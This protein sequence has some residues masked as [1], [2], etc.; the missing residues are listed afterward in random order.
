MKRFLA[1]LLIIAMLPIPATFAQKAEPTVI[2]EE[3][4]D[5]VYAD[6]W[7]DIEDIETAKI[8]AKRGRNASADDYAAIVD[9]VIAAVE[10]SDTFVE[11]SIHRNG[12]FFTWKTT[13]GVA[14][15]YSP[16]LRA[17]IRNTAIKDADPEDYADIETTSYAV[18]GGSPS[19]K[20]VA[21][22][23]PYYGLDSSFTTTYPNEAKAIAQATGG[24]ATTYKTSAATIDAIADALESCAVVIF[25]SHGDTD[26]YSMTDKYDFVSR[27]NTSYICLQSGAGLTTADMADVTGTYGTYNH[28]YYGGTDYENPSMKYYCV[29]GTVIANH[30]EK[31]APNSMLWM[32]ICLGMATDGLEKPL[33]NKGVEVVYGY[34]Q[35]V[36]FDYDYDWESVFWK[37]MKND[38]TVAQSISAMKT[39]VGEW[40]DCTNKDCNTIAKARQNYCAFPI[41]VSSE[42]AYPGKGNVDNLQTVK[43][44]WKLKGS[45]TPTELT[46]ATE[47]TEPTEPITGGTFKKVTA[48][49]SDWSGKYLIVNETSAD[50]CIVF[51]GTGDKGAAMKDIAISSGTVNYADGM[52]VVTVA[53]C[54]SGYSMRLDNGSYLNEVPG[55]NGLALAASPAEISISMG[56]GSPDVIGAS[57][58]V[59]RYNPSAICFR[60]YGG[61]YMNQREIQLYKQTG[62]TPDP[63][64]ESTAKPTDPTEPTEP[65]EGGSFAKVTAEQSDWSG[66]Y[67]LAFEDS[68]TS[69]VV[70]KGSDAQNDTVSTQTSNGRIAYKEGMAIVTVKKCGNGYSM[71]LENGTYL[72]SKPLDG[73][74]KEQNGIVCSDTEAELV[75]NIGTDG[76][77]IIAA[78]GSRLRY[79][80]T[81]SEG[82]FR[83][84]KSTTYINQKAVQLYKLEGEIPRPTEP[85]TPPT[86]P[87]TPPTEPTT[88]PTQPTTPPTQP[89]TPPTQPTTPPTQPT[90][91]TSNKKVTVKS[92]NEDM[93][94]VFLM[95]NVATAIPSNGYFASG[96]LIEPADA[97]TVMQEGNRFYLSNITKDCCLTVQFRAKETAEVH[98]SVPAG[99]STKSVSATIGEP[100][101]LKEPEGRI[102]ADAHEYEFIGWTE[103]RVKDEPEKPVVYTD[104]FTPKDEKT[105][106]YALYTYI[107]RGERWYSTVLQMETCLAKKFT[108]VDTKAWYHEALDFV[109][110]YQ[111]MKGVDELKFDPN[112][113]LTRGMLVTILYRL[114]ER[115]EGWRHPFE[116]VEDD[117]W[118]AEPV[119]WAYE[120][121][122]V[123]GTSKTEFSPDAPITREQ[124]AAML[125]RY[126][127]WNGEDVTPT[128][129]LMKFAD[130]EKVSA[131]ARNPLRWAVGEGIINGKG[132]IEDKDKTGEKDE[133]TDIL[134][135]LGTATRAEIA[136]ILMGWLS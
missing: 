111:Y 103:E 63:T 31:S 56:A 75:I 108:D 36:T 84:Y 24:T 29:D 77:D 53:K 69:A 11:G 76:T 65:I 120:N 104:F 18:R 41:V 101:E 8:V 118:Y 30:M 27:A 110:E 119:A 15:G 52:A 91:P 88:P 20:N 48:E 46:E 66:K 49:Q 9:D 14:C 129:S 57:G 35:S 130:A 134:D 133:A 82:R 33:H 121:G 112:G 55:D 94:K 51:T 81:A 5:A 115:E 39:E 50:K 74:G 25:D 98:F 58:T 68:T 122:I 86:E 114:E 132:K 34:S 28:A 42:D 90:T 123:N 37:N 105:T 3:A 6:V 131:F 72:D 97:A 10:A 126:A 2:P 109:L 96:F 67:L 85:T 43:S 44:T 1:I 13:E 135:P 32:A 61:S 17:Q 59:L 117:K 79:N 70:Y 26:Y 95:D 16:R 19:A 45:V 22:F 40:D 124:A 71:Q 64:E 127:K 116:D 106:L 62:T 47:S 100:V 7:E 99:C 102:R 93:G 113:K 73:S 23:Q 107:Y 87:T 78:T 80:A 92:A 128:G 83:F 4:Y 89:T 21:V 12:A 125:Y 136:K 54:G 60:F 38:K